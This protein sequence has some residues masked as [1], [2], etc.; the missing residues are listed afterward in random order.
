MLANNY[1]RYLYHHGD[2]VSQDDTQWCVQNDLR[3]PF[4]ELGTDLSLG[5]ELESRI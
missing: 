4:R 5:E 2:K 1:T 3:F